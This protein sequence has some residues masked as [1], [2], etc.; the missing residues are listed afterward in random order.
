MGSRS[1]RRD[2]TSST[3]QPSGLLV[4]PEE[5][6]RR[7]RSE[8]EDEEPVADGATV[9]AMWALAALSNVV[10]G[11][12]W[13]VSVTL[14]CLGLALVAGAASHLVVDVFTWAWMLGR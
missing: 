11:V 5:E 1:R 13:V 7:E 12:V 2:S 4:S 3:G 14:V 10:K 6:Q 9:M 8:L